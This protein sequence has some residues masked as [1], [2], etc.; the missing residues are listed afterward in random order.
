MYSVAPT[1]WNPNTEPLLK[2]IEASNGVN[3]AFLFNPVNTPVPSEKISV[4]DYIIPSG[5]TLAQ[6]A[7]LAIQAPNT[8]FLLLADDNMHLVSDIMSLYQTFKIGSIDITDSVTLIPQFPA[9]PVVPLVQTGYY[10]PQSSVPYQ[11]PVLIDPAESSFSSSSGVSTAVENT[12]Q[13][14]NFNQPATSS[15]SKNTPQ[16]LKPNNQLATSPTTGNNPP[17]LNPNQAATLSTSENTSQNLNP[18]EPA[19]SSTSENAP[20]NSNSNQPANYSPSENTLQD[21]KPN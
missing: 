12:P 13:N 2:A 14:L 6:F 20:K 1:G 5:M 8:P 17:N 9:Q 11:S 3:T 21:P 18:N 15:A 7:N 10:R 19:T 4:S 16:N